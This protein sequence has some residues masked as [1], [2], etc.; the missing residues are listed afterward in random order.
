MEEGCVLHL[1][2]TNHKPMNRRVVSMLLVLCF[3][4]IQACS[5]TKS[6]ATNDR[7]GLTFETAVIVK[8]INEEYSWVREHYPGSQMQMQ[9]LVF[10]GKTPYDVLTFRLADGT[11]QK[12]HF[13]ISKFYGRGF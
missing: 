7:D 11:T 13:D 4:I 10:Q 2:G 9:A 5:S 3:L 8:S 12:F 1:E 6:V